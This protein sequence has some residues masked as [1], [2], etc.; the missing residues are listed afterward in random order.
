MLYNIGVE[1]VS[2]HN[3]MQVECKVV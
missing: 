2:H 3:N 1:K